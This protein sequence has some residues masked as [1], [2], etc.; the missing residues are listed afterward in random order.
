MT[1]FINYILIGI[2]VLIGSILARSPHELIEFKDILFTLAVVG[3]L[4]FFWPII[5]VYGAYCQVQNCKEAW[6]K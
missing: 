4:V 1:I 6:K 5:I 3:I 2:G